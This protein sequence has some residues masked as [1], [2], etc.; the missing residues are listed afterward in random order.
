[1]AENVQKIQAKMADVNLLKQHDRKINF[2]YS[3]TPS[4]HLTSSERQT[5]DKSA[6]ALSEFQA[7]DPN[8]PQ[9]LSTKRSIES[10]ITL[11]NKSSTRDHQTDEKSSAISMARHRAMIDKFRK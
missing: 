7:A 9:K 3:T 2:V 8:T 1:M 4:P 11:D 6:K 5:L 10:P